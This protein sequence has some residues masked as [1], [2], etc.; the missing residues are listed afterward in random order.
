MDNYSFICGPKGMVQTGEEEFYAGLH[1]M[2]YPL[3]ISRMFI[4]VKIQFYVN[5]NL[6]AEVK[7]AKVMRGYHCNQRGLYCVYVLDGIDVENVKEMKIFAKIVI[8]ELYDMSG[9]KVPEEKWMEHNVKSK[10][11]SFVVE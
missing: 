5:S 2:S 3:G 9:F 7:D 6:Y 11:W 4:K 10:L 8:K 1:L